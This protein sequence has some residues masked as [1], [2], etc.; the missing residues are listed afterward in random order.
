M[1][2]KST[3]KASVVVPNWN[4][5]DS[6]GACLDSLLAQSLRP[7]IIVVENGSRDGSL[8][9]LEKN[10][11]SA[12]VLSNKKNLGFTGGVNVGIR[13][14]IE[15]GDEFVALLN[16]DAVAGSD[17][18]KYLL[19]ELESERNV[20]IATC[21]ILSAD[22]KS[23]DSTGDY[24]TN[25]GLPYPRGRGETELDKYDKQ[26][27]IF[28]ASG[29][30]SLYRVKMLKEI[31]LFDEDFFA[32]YEDVDISFRAQLA[33]WK[34]RYVPQA[35]VFHKIG[36]TSSKLKG[37]TTYQTMKNLPVLLWKNVPRRYLFTIGSRF[38][39]AHIL[40]F[41]RAVTRGL[42]WTALKGDAA[43]TYLLIKKS[44][45]RRRIQSSKKVS[46][47][48]IWNMTVHDLPPNAG[49]LRNLR[50]KWRKIIGNSL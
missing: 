48:Y 2:T 42:G 30:A 5:K 1:A 17:W 25:W 13:R 33:G 40:F 50:A 44:G 31:G 49:A 11:P 16:N 43:S 34:V 29:G 38:F 47:Q 26:T 37:F 10:Y 36:A 27:E 22:G 41:G 45:E 6:L 4:G 21:K 14:A 9:F 23:L 39:I 46:D 15:L 20:G 8:E 32:Y 7:H 19:A 24:Y 18:L 35:K 3:V 28:A 12:E